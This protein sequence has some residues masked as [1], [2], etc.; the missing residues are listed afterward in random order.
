VLSKVL[1]KC[2]KLQALTA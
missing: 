1:T 2:F